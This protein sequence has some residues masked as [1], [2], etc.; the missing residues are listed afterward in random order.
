MKL[1]HHYHVPPKWTVAAGVCRNARQR[2]EYIWR[3]MHPTNYSCFRLAKREL[4]A[5]ENWSTKEH[6][7]SVLLPTSL[8]VAKP[9]R[10]WH[11]GLAFDVIFLAMELGGKKRIARSSDCTRGARKMYKCVKWFLSVRDP[12]TQ[13]CAR[14]SRWL[15]N[16]FTPMGATM[17]NSI[18][19]IPR[20]IHPSFFVG[21]EGRLCQGV[22]RS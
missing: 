22:V 12:M 18:Q 7:L 16:H 20:W 1:A 5:T 11:M 15:P 10:K 2:I 4:I 8:E 19:S 6:E 17:T 14:Q 13:P 3:K 9:V 21:D